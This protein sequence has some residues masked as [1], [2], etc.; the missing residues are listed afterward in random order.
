MACPSGSTAILLLS[1]AKCQQ[2]QGSAD[3]R[4]GI[5]NASSS[6]CA[7]E[8]Q[9]L[10]RVL[11]KDPRGQRLEDQSQHLHCLSCSSNS[12]LNTISQTTQRGNPSQQ[13]SVSKQ[14]FQGPSGLGPGNVSEVF[15]LGL[16]HRATSSPQEGEKRNDQSKLLVNANTA[17]TAH[18][19]SG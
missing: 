8:S 1:P 17:L 3:P 9:A 16:R 11:Q 5:T 15:H 10:E 4:A 6:V 19:S 18:R 13:R 2:E 14:A 12:I 7:L